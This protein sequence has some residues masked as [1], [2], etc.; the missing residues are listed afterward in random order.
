MYVILYNLCKVTFNLFFGLYKRTFCQI[1]I[2]WLIWTWDWFQNNQK[3]W[4]FHYFSLFFLNILF[5][6]DWRVEILLEYSINT[7]DEVSSFLLDS[8]DVL[9]GQ[10]QL[11]NVH[12]LQVGTVVV[13]CILG[14][15]S[16]HQKL[17]TW[18]VFHVLVAGYW[19]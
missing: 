5:L 12:A 4:N 6:C 10:V 19:V 17:R 15:R 16:H 7:L 8:S 14:S 2:W 3:C 9:W 18:T 11:Y 13:G 1:T